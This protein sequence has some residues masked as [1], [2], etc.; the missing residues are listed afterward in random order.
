MGSFSRLPEFEKEFSRLAKKYPSLSE[1]F[2]KFEKLVLLNPLGIG[3]NF[4]VTHR[5]PT[6]CIVKARLA[7]KSLRDRS[8][9]VIYSHHQEKLE[10]VYIELYAKGGKANEDQKRIKDYLKGIVK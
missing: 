7:C 4:A 3:A 9:R 6:V 10:F 5:S 1:D 8:L 2:K